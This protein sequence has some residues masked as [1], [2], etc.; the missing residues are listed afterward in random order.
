MARPEIP[1]ATLAT[2]ACNDKAPSEVD[3]VV[4]GGGIAGVS[5]ALALAERG[6]RV[7]VCEKGRIAGE[8]SSRNWGWVRQMGRDPA[9][10]PL[11]IESLKIWRTLDEKHRIETGFRETGIS[12]LCR[13]AREQTKVEQW[14]ETGKRFG[15]SQKVLDS[16]GIAKLLPGAA[17]GF[18][19][20]LH[21]PSDGRAEP[22]LAVPALARAAQGLGAVMLDSCA[23]RGIETASGNV[24]AA[25]TEHGPVRCNAVIVAGGAWS[26]L[27]LGNLGV[28]FPQLKLLATA[29]RVDGVHDA[30]GMP[31]GGGDFAFRRRLDGGF[32]V[33]LRNTNIAPIVPDSVRLFAEFVPAVKRHWH[34]LRLEI[35]KQFLTELAMPRRWAADERT[36]F[37]MHRTLDPAP[38]ASLIRKALVT[39][40]RAFPLFATA[41]ITHTW[42]GL[43]DVTPDEL[44]VI[45][46]V[47]GHPGLYLVSGF[48]GH[49]FGTGPAAGQLMAQLVTRETP[50]V[51]PEPF[52]LSRFGSVRPTPSVQGNVAA[53]RV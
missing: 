37:E 48:S 40:R 10:M 3:V 35:G 44:P 47:E 4:V 33:A 45:D 28:R 1:I 46:S 50:C 52:R 21:T 41:Q 32:T 39:L 51:D 24:S 18:T 8:Q 49:G 30:P 23:V 2:V 38:R 53:G 14:E 34:E 6:V 5:T 11:A 29:G 22:S 31:V 17:S 42:A 15:V 16:G 27:F 9:E 36:P 25:V 43:I 19:L 26:R 13:N 20:G 7:C 12:Y